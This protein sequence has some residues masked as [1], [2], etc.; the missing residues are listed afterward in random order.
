MVTELIIT[1]CFLIVAYSLGSMLTRRQ[2][3]GSGASR[4]SLLTPDDE[5]YLATDERDD[6]EN[7]QSE[8]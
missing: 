4:T 7:G 2:P 5:R 8:Q 1:I 6:A 3:D